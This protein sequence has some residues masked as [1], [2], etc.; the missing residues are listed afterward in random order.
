M[1]W[2]LGVDIGGTF[3]DLCAHDEAT[4]AVH[5]LK[6]LSRP[7]LPGVDVAAAIAD[8]ARLHDVDLAQVTRFTHG[9]T[10]GVNTIIQRRGATLA[11]FATD[12]F[13]DVLELARLRM[14]DAYS[15]FG[16]RAAPLVP[17]D[18]VF[19][20]AGRLLAD[21]TQLQP[22]DPASVDAAIAGA[23]ARGCAGVVI[24]LLH[25]WRNPAHE[26]EVARIVAARAPDL[27]VF[28][29]TEIW[30]AIREYERTSTAV[31]NGYVHPRVALYLERLEAVLA[32]AGVVARPLIT[33]S[34][35]GVMAARQGRRDCV[36]MLLS[37]TACGVMGAAFVAAE[38]GIRHAATLDVGGTSAD[39]ALLLDGQAQ[40]AA[41]ENVGGFPLFVPSVAVSSIGAGGGSIARVDAFGLL[42][43]GPDS[44]GSMPG[45]ACYGRGG[46]EATLTDAFAVRGVLGHG[47]L[48]F[49]AVRPD[50]DAA[51]VAVGKVAARLGRS[52]EETAEA[53]AAVAVSA[54]Y[55]EFSKLFARN[56]VD[57]TD[58]TLIAFGG[59][60][61]MVGC[62]LARELGLRR[63]LV[64]RAPGVVCALGGLVAEIRNDLLRTVMLPL[65]P[66][67]VDAF[68][69]GFA[70]LERDAQAWLAD[71]GEPGVAGVVQVSADMRYRGQSYEIEVP[72]T[73]VTCAAMAAAFHARH[74]AVFDHADPAAAVEVVNLRLSIRA[75]APG[76]ASPVLLPAD[77]PPP[78]RPTRIFLD[79]AW[80]DVALYR[81]ADLRAGHTIA[82]PAVV[83]QDDTTVLLPAQSQAVVQSH[84][85]L[86]VTL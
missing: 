86:L 72:L 10:V 68:K 71:V 18:R 39:V 23:R 42:K 70:A 3:T 83:A 14:P 32:E 1:G 47:A 40:F 16:E 80:R 48:G 6:V 27:F 8:V 7:D 15:L 13:T 63:M 21:G 12:G 30:P 60:G 19:P 76:I 17:K 81:R 33:R 41:G 73:A 58:M 25:A 50:V 22:I 9:T 69:D 45:P 36:G 34:N 29:S 62:A 4:G 74:H 65:A 46:T 57:L 38:A 52:E 37:G 43:V 2:R 44:A 77:G 20:V 11:L 51:R 78:S 54:M 67:S 75:G 84:G 56:A 24:C 85:H 49:G 53:I 82:G 28:R 35:G 64:P 66:E 26:I 31:L 79:G 59:A 5:T 55:L 61:P